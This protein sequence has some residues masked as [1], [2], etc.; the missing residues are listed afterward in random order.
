L[1]QHVIYAAGVI[2]NQDRGADVGEGRPS[3]S[4]QLMPYAT[5]NRVEDGGH[6][7]KAVNLTLSAGAVSRTGRPMTDRGKKK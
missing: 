5:V 7:Q 4:A 2:G 3:I 1:E 6:S